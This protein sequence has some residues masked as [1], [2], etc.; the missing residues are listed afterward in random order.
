MTTEA[1]TRQDFENSL[2][3]TMLDL[4]GNGDFEHRGV[5]AGEYR[6]HLLVTS[7]VKCG[8]III[9]VASSIGYSDVA[10][11]AGQNSIRLWLSDGGGM[12]LGSK[13]SRWVTRMSG[14]E[15]RMDDQIKRLF[16]MGKS[17]KFCD[18]CNSLQ[19]VFIVKKDG[20]NKG[21]LFKHC[22]CA[23]DFH[24]LADERDQ[25]EPA[26]TVIEGM[27]HKPLGNG[28]TVLQ[29]AYKKVQEQKAAEPT[30]KAFTPSKYQRAIFDWIQADKGKHLVVEALAGSG[31]TT[32]GVEALKLIPMTQSVVFVAFNKHIAVELQRR[33]ED[34][35]HIK[36][37]TYHSLGYAAVRQAFGN[38]QMDEDKVN[39]ILDTILDR[40]MYR[41]I[42]PV[43]RQL[44]SLVKANLTG[45]TD[46]DLTGLAEHYGIELNGDSDT[47]FTAVALVIEKSAKMTNVIDYDDMCWMP[48]HLNLPCKQYDFLFVDEAQ[49]TN[50]NQIAL[51]LKSVKKN[52]RIVAV[53]DRYQC[54]PVGTLVYKT[55][56]G[57]VPIDSIG[58][59]DE[60]MTYRDGYFSGKL[61]QGRKVISAE[62]HD[63][64]GD[65][66][67][68]EA[69]DYCH[70]VTPEHRCVIRM[71]KDNGWA[72]YVMLRGDKARVGTTKSCDNPAGSVAM[73]GRQEN[74]DAAWILDI[75]HDRDSAHL[76]ENMIAYKYGIP[77]TNFRRKWEINSST[78]RVQTW[79]DKFWAMFP[80]NVDSLKRC[81]V[82]YGRD[83]EYPFWAISKNGGEFGKKRGSLYISVT[84]ACNLIDDWMKVCTFD[85]N[86]SAKY[87]NWKP[88]RVSRK[89]YSGAVYSIELES[90]WRG[91]PVYV[92]QGIVT[93]NSLYGFRG[94][95]VDAI[96]NLIDNLQAETL[97][98]SITYRCPK[99][100][101]EM[102]K[103]KFPM[104]PLEAPEWAK[105]GEMRH[106]TAN[107]ADTEYTPGDMVLCRTNAPLVE[108]AFSLIRRGIKAIIRGRDIGKGLTVLVRKMKAN[109]MG[110]LM[111]KLVEY[112]SIEVS[113]LLNAEK[114]SQAQA[115]QDKVDTIVALS[116]GL[117]SIT[118]L[119]IRIEDIF[120]DENEGVVFS[121]VHRAKGL[122][123]QR[124]YILRADLMP[125]SMAKKD[126]E[127][128][129]ESNIQYVAYTRTLETLTFVE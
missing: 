10:D 23:G 57:Y 95:D 31:K 64:D 65:I 30:K 103:Q 42:F 50:K 120:S 29:N 18:S 22:K 7:N 45:T 73:R 81:L 74:A 6:Y 55:G 5:I 110:D 114:G 77:Q 113:K 80:S 91:H 79:L 35:P 26:K 44:V 4:T 123:A 126:W 56:V 62:H 101:V 47:V 67:H 12:P 85:G 21:R 129:Q 13:I 69:G 93:H 107:I 43:I 86:A 108:P 84:Q 127:L 8:K 49:D 63:Y 122:E 27:N 118:E 28:K 52:G 59:G 17:L 41:P 39:H 38:V 117:S 125:H 111:S 1:F 9:E 25:E 112:K 54:H 87:S 20:A 97:P 105:D 32:T 2:K 88:V 11:P 14:W 90:S 119:E 124:V 46:E 89:H 98:L 104:I 71:N 75:F 51:A 72:V 70:D 106:I 24:W 78:I 76:F 100:I 48:I 102:V 33:L 115:L 53:G 61:A 36:V 82:D 37:S 34:Q 16:S 3:S 99:C 121:S 83:I 60:L 128:Q 92:A 66:I 40:Y 94:A 19:H 58:V 15:K 96:P 109:D 116:D 68:I